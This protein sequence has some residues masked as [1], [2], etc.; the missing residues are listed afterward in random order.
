M[1]YTSPVQRARVNIPRDMAW[2]FPEVD[3]AVL[4]TEEHR[5][6]ILA[7]VLERGRLEDVRWVLAHYGSEQIHNFFRH[8]GSPELSPRTLGF[9]RAY[10]RA[11]NER[12]KTPPSWRTSNSVPWP[13]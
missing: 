4:D 5:D 8:V 11:E 12:W 1:T 9:W 2:L 10:F 7:R 6:F 13:S 3:L